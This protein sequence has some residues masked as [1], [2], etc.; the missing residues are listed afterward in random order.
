[1]AALDA[2]AQPGTTTPNVGTRYDNVQ[3]AL[4]SVR[5]KESSLTLDMTYT[6]QVVYRGRNYGLIQPGLAPSLTYRHRLGWYALTTNYYWPG[7]TGGIARTDIGAGYQK[8]VT[9]WLNVDFL[10][11]RWIY[12]YGN[13]EIRNSLNNY[14]AGNFTFYPKHM[15]ITATAYYSWGTESTISTQ[16][17]VSGDFQLPTFIPHTRIYIRPQVLAI[18][19]TEVNIPVTE[20]VVVRRRARTVQR[21]GSEVFAVVDY[22]F[23]VPVVFRWGRV[24]LTPSF[25]YAFPQNLLPEEAGATPYP[26]YTVQLS[27]PF[28]FKK[29]PA[30][31]GY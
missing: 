3:D 12:H 2:L 21:P 23:A 20:Q 11:E 29:R 15:I 14:L 24:E 7:T 22:E 6:S 27:V 25:H 9:D 19:A 26:Y 5:D 18:W 16:L 10:Y 8:D 1:M 17:N 28:Y 30:V 31:K 13:D 4:D